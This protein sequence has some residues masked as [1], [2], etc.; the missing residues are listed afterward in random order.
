MAIN[1]SPGVY[2]KIID[3]ST[4][5]AGVPSTIGFIPIISDRGEDNRLIMTNGRDFYQDFGEPN[6]L[7]A[8]KDFGQGP[9]IASSF[10]SQ[11][12]SLYVLRVMPESA[13]WANIF[14]TT[15]TTSGAVD[16]TSDVQIFSRDGITKKS[17]INTAIN[18]D[19]LNNTFGNRNP[20]VVFYGVGRGS[21]YN[22]LKIEL[23]KHANPHPD[24][25]HI[26]ILNVYQK[27]YTR[28]AL[29]EGLLNEY[30]IVEAF[31]VSFDYQALDSSG[32]SIWIEDVINTYSRTI[33]C[34]ANREMC[35]ELFA[36]GVSFT[37]PFEAVGEEPAGPKLLGG[38]SD[39]QNNYIPGGEDDPVDD[40]FFDEFGK[41]NTGVIKKY[42]TKAYHGTLVK[43]DDTMN[44]T[45]E[46]A[47]LFVDEVL[48]TENY[49]FSI[50]L[51][52][53]YPSDVKEAISFLVEQRKDCVAVVD[54]GD[55]PNAS[56]AL[57][58]RNNTNDFNSKYVALYE[59]YSKVY[60]S[61]LG[62]DIWISPVYHMANIIPY[63]DNVSEIWYAPAG[64]N[65]AMISSIKEMR[66]SPT[67]GQRDSFYLNQIN[68]IVKFNVGYTVFGQL[69]T[70]RR[71]SALQDLNIVR[72]VLYVKR[73]L[74][75]YCRFY[76]FEQND[77]S[78][79]SSIRNDISRFLTDIQNRRGLNTFSVEVGATDY[80][81]R[82]KKMHVNVTLDPTRT[83][84][85][86]E[87]NFFIK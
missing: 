16:A 72:M 59:P 7:Y 18:G 20:F 23:T 46:T 64:M 12:D 4:Y 49:Y 30:S 80:E 53:G 44:Q 25:D 5:V 17:M 74:E 85:Q 28:N 14:L 83:V 71:P 21:Y 26:C 82:Q 54:N 40:R 36:S 6:I 10:L 65:R 76:I 43:S 48:D 61:F 19:T 55:N 70:Q 45:D 15:N 38:G 33:R 50:V 56:I 66:Y 67:K 75:Q 68:P 2:T 78:T 13:T 37:A 79:W 69:T 84:E 60:D 39:G 32:E 87:L 9:Y 35:R 31:E 58:A 63:T 29:D 42:L 62:R 86:I 22:N 51:D 8:G 73:A 57:A 11:S 81:M 27:L 1:I 47:T 34:S 3:L 77:S 41:I 52:G 24:Y